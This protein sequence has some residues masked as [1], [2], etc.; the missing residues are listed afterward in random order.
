MTLQELLYSASRAGYDAQDHVSHLLF[1]LV[2]R[3]CDA[4]LQDTFTMLPTP[5]KRLLRSHRPNSRQLFDDEACTSALEMFTCASNVSLLTLAIKS[6]SAAPSHRS[7]V[8]NANHCRCPPTPPRRQP[9]RD[10]SRSTWGKPR[11][12]P[13]SFKNGG[14]GPKD[15]H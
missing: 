4:Y 13:S 3:R 7:S 9:A 10:S 15:K 6:R 11:S 14:G 8:T 5:T 2:L 1:N 12:F